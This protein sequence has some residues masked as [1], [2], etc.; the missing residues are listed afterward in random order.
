MNNNYGLSPI[1]E[2]LANLPTVYEIRDDTK[3]YAQFNR[4]AIVKSKL[5]ISDKEVC[6]GMKMVAPVIL[7]THTKVEKK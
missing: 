1:G 3:D 5:P 4:S 2:F 6:E 7:K